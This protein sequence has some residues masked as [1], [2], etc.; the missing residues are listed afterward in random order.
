MNAGRGRYWGLLL[1]CLLAV[2]QP[3][4]AQLSGR[5][6]YEVGT[7]ATDAGS[8]EGSGQLGSGFGVE[9]GYAFFADSRLGL[10][11]GAKLLVRGFGVSISDRVELDMGVFDQSDLL[12]D[13]FVAVQFSGVVAGAYFEQR[14]IDRGTRLGTI[15]VPASGVGLFVRAPLIGGGR[16]EA[17]FTYAGFCGGRL[18]LQ[19]IS[20]EPALSSGRSIR[21][22]VRHRLTD[23]WGVRGEIGD[24]ELSFEP[25]EPTFSFFDHRQRSLTAGLTL[26][27]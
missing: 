19:G 2:S 20:T 10:V 25:V 11:V 13:Q 3:A 7:L 24:I 5:A 1:V 26:G 21:L 23:R 18:R 15:G 17:E 4:W 14:R 16:T 27:F 12:L 8:D 9:G 6:V 22:I